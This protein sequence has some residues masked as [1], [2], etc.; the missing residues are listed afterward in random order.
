MHKFVTTSWFTRI[1]LFLAGASLTFA[2]QGPLAEGDVLPELIWTDQRIRRDVHVLSIGRKHIILRVDG[3]VQPL[4]HE[5]FLNL[6]WTT[7]KSAQLIKINQLALEIGGGK[8]GT[9]AVKRVSAGFVIPKLIWTDGQPKELVEILNTRRGYYVM[10]VEGKTQVLDKQSF[11]AILEQTKQFL[12]NGQHPLPA[13]PPPPGQPRPL[14]N[15]P[16]PP[17]PPV[18]G[19][20]PP[21]SGKSGL[22]PPPQAKPGQQPPG[23]RP[24]Y[25]DFQF[26]GDKP[27]PPGQGSEPVPSQ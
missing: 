24:V 9:P 10:R 21:A 11:L 4:T 13:L 27:T 8:P 19:M 23:Q 6:Y 20:P 22:E 14:G 25:F 1:C 17:A 18:K 12:E 26:E 3:Q 7:Q 2:K 16:P 15:L 5:N